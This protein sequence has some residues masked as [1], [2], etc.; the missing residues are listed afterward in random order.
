[1]QQNETRMQRTIRKATVKYQ[2]RIK[3]LAGA[4]ESAVSRCQCGDSYCL[5][6]REAKDL[7]SASEELQAMLAEW[8]IELH[9]EH[10]L[11]RK[12]A[13]VLIWQGTLLKARIVASIAHEQGADGGMYPVVRLET[14]S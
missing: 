2:L 1:M 13:E 10:A 11:N 5:D 8:H 7:L 12:P 3:A 4:L 14:T 6:C 9:S